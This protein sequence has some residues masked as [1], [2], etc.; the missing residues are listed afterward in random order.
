MSGTAL[1]FICEAA[2]HQPRRKNQD[3]LSS[4]PLTIHEG[5]W[6]Y[7]RAGLLTGHEW[8]AIAPTP[9]EAIKRHV[10]ELQKT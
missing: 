5:K 9:F 1:H 7:C 4:S 3:G 8:R 2:Q 6:A 10:R